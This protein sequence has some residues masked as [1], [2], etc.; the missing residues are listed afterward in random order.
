M[1]RGY[2]TC[3]G[4]ASFCLISTAFVIGGTGVASAAPSRAVSISLSGTWDVQISAGT[5]AETIKF[6]TSNGTFKENDTHGFGD[7]GTYALSGNKL[8]LRWT[9]GTSE[10]L[11]FHGGY[12][13]AE[14]E[15]IGTYEN[16]VGE[17][18][19]GDLLH[20]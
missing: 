16:A 9:G 1:Y 15:F 12:K 7:H 10:G 5:I 18:S 4:V 11:R 8:K 14:R 20:R 13:S 3:L 17:T 2:V 6:D 19:K